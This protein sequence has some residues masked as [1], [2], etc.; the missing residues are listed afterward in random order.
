M[1][2]L[3]FILIKRVGL[4]LIIAFVLTLIPG[5]KAL[6]YREVKRSMTIIYIFIF[7]IFG[8][9]SSTLVI[10][11]QEN[12]IITH[13]LILSVENNALVISLSLV[14]IVIAGLLG[15]PA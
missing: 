3:I 9:V 4:L 14:A 6:L 8:I 7:V 2:D 13:R 1:K 5:F 11:I 12:E 10:I 15:G